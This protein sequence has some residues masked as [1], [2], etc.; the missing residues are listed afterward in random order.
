M[1]AIH[2]RRYR[3]LLGI[4][5]V[6]SLAG[7]APDGPT[8]SQ[9]PE[10]AP[11]SSPS[12]SL[13]TST[14]RTD[15]PAATLDALPDTPTEDFLLTELISFPGVFGEYEPPSCME[16]SDAPVPSV[17]LGHG[18]TGLEVIF[19]SPTIL[20]LIGFNPGQPIE[21]SVSVGSSTYRSTV[22]P[23][24][25]PADSFD[26]APEETLF[27]GQE[28]AA[29][30]GEGYLESKGWRF[31]PP[32]P[33]RDELAAN[34]QLTITATQGE[35]Q[36]TT[37]QPLAPLDEPGQ[38]MLEDWDQNRG[39]FVPHGLAIWGFEPGS[40]LP[41]GLYRVLKKEDDGSGVAELV[42]QIGE[43]TIPSSG[44]AVFDI[45]PHIAAE[46]ASPNNEYC[47]SGPFREDVYSCSS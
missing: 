30:A 10:S 15:T 35:L 7:C 43:V 21:I 4:T 34:G 19:T 6:A 18:G 2:P 9:V 12:T 5:L 40:R 17:I 11:S 45:P 32:L 29:T 23:Q 20:C 38:T 46:F 31:I 3:I 39:M 25:G 1:R 36:A 37:T 13:E 47:I 26:T 24:P 28:L 33:V 16:F 44:L 41:I 14:S 27:E 8:P 42:Q 22:G